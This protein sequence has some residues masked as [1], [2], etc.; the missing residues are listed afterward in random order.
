MSVAVQKYASL[1]SRV[2][3][4]DD[5]NLGIRTLGPAKDTAAAP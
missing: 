2:R 5:A 4:H 3:Q 1:L